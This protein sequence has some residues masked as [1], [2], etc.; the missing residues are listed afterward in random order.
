MALAVVGLSACS[1]A[2]SERPPTAGPTASFG[3]S[4]AE[5]GATGGGDTAALTWGRVDLGFVSAYILVRHGEAAIVDTGVSGSA[6][7]IE[8]G[9]VSLGLAWSDVGHLIL[10]HL[11]PDHVGSAADVMERAAAASGYAG[12]ADLPAID[13]PRPLVA[14]G[15]GDRVFDLSIIETPGHTAGHIVVLDDVAGV[16][17]A[18]DALNTM[19]G[20]VTGP[21]PQ[22]SDDMTTAE[23]S[24]RKL[25]A[26]TFDTLL[27]GHGDPIT[28]RA[29]ELVAAL[30]AGG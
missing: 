7:H 13:V 26:F 19:D 23:A 5:G 22:F 14:V 20:T 30:A 9:L 1:P 25:A 24:V 3:S 17:V 29:S 16:L 6:G 18:G 27:V 15:D 4:P 10:T 28:D 21:N 2:A 12:A 11:H 8:A